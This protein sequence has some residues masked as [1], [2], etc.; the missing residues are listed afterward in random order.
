MAP[1]PQL[2]LACQVDRDSDG[3]SHALV[4]GDTLTGDVERRAVVD[5]R[6][7]ERQAEVH[8]DAPLPVVHLDGDVPLVVVHGE[9]D[10][11]LAVDRLSEHGVRG[12]RPRRVDA[13]RAGLF[14]SRG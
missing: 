12:H 4:V 8:A 9:D 5:R 10:I 2:A 14:L 6:S 13:E 11:V 7:D 1:S 3:L